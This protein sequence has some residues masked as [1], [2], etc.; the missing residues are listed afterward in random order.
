MEFK[1]GNIIH[2]FEIK[3][4][5][6]V[7]DCDCDLI[8]MKHIK[9]GARLLYLDREDENKTFSIAF[10]TIP[11]NDTGVFH[12]LEHSVL[13]GSKKYP[14]KEPFVEL[15]KSSMQTFLNAMTYPDKTM[16]PVSS[17]NEKDFMN[18]MD[19]YL[20]A[21]F[22]PAIYTCPNIFYQEGWHYEITD[23]N[24]MPEYSGVVYSEMQGAFSSIDEIILNEANATL[25]KDTCY[26]YESGGDPSSIVHLS[27][28][29]F[30][31]A[32][33]KYYHPSNAYIFLDGSMDINKVLEKIDTEY[34]SEY[35]KNNEE[36]TIPYQSI[37]PAVRKVRNYEIDENE[38]AANRTVIAY[39]KIVA[40]YKDVEKNI[41][42]GALQ[43]LLVGSN[44][45]VL[46]KALLEKGL[47]EDAEIAMIDGILQPYLLLVI[48]N[49]NIEKEKEIKEVITHSIKDLINK[50]LDIEMIEA[51]LNQMEFS[52]REP[53]EPVGV[54]F[55]DD[56]LKSWLHNDDPMIYLNRGH[57]YDD[58]RSKLNTTYFSDLLKEFFLDEEHLSTMIF[59][60]SKTLAKERKELVQKELEE[61]KASWDNPNKYIELCNNLHAWQEEKDTKE[62]LNTLPKLSLEDIKK[63]SEHIE[64]ET[65]EIRGVPVLV[66]PKEKSGIVYMNLYFSIAGVRIDD[67]PLVTFYARLLGDLPTE[68][69]DV[70]ELQKRIRRDIGTL[71]ISSTVVAVKDDLTATKPMI[72]VSLSVLKHKVDDALDLVFEIL[73]HTKFTPED[74]KP[75]VSQSLESARQVLSTSGHAI[76]QNITLAMNSAASNATEHMSGFYSMKWMSHLN[77]NYD[78][79]IENFIDR[80]YLY[81]DIFFTSS[82]LTA[83][84]SGSEN[85]LIVEKVIDT[86]PRQQFERC[87]VHYPLRKKENVGIIAPTQVSYIAMSS[88]IDRE[89]YMGHMSVLGHILTYEYLW[90]EIRV[91]RGAYGTGFSAGNTGII[92]SY[93][94]RDPSPATSIETV[95][96]AYKFIEPFTLEHE[97]LSTYIIGTLAHGSPL[98]SPASKIRSADRLYFMGI[99]YEDRQNNRNRILSTTVEDLRKMKDALKKALEEAP[100]AVVGPKEALESCHIPQE[101]IE[102]L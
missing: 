1:T 63:E 91:K 21:V 93:S 95:R 53:S 10:K 23:E 41:A 30:I 48:R 100:F 13:N 92:S 77:E 2:G 68:K 44:E 80:C 14:V 47:C 16:Y 65:R 27:Y 101:N 90:N 7:E 67:L 70:E 49:T 34:L 58:L 87:I 40:D 82:R 83:S 17:R 59:E 60:P 57:I 38:D 86:L 69:Y 99:T 25:F 98:Q 26:K 96:N 81:S 32:H 39:G 76:A 51:S 9:S 88:S 97:D 35:T 24:K 52:Y 37:L 56:A 15:L 75:F 43:D 84:I 66:Y 22:H 64:P 28:E 20:D 54:M 71:G 62:A 94:Y 79:E 8:T 12:I 11:E 85:L 29:D 4:V 89:K 55:A 3:K 31:G 18:L 45:S 42:Y 74:I 102:K 19:T 33:K 50:G 46:K 73:Q 72:V 6:R 78:T 5:E 36:F 61:A